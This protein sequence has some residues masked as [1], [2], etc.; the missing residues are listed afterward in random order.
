MSE[1]EGNSAPSSD[2]PTRYLLKLFVSGATPRS[3]NAIANLKAICERE[4]AG[5]YE[6]EV[7]D[8][9]QQPEIVPEKPD[10]RFTHPDQE[11]TAANPPLDWRH[12]RGRESTDWTGP[13][14]G[15]L[16]S[17]QG[18]KLCRTRQ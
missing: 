2:Q 14:S 18:A 13:A 10:N 11:P 5:R 12:V 1:T 7:I 6:L 16:T 4:L 17:W 15:S 8:I 9:F 3:T